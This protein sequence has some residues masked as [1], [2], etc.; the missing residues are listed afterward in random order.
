MTTAE[1]KIAERVSYARKVE[2]E[3]GLLLEGGPALDSPPIAQVRKDLKRAHDLSWALQV[4]PLFD[5]ACLLRMVIQHFTELR[6]SF[7]GTGP[8]YTGGLWV[9]AFASVPVSGYRTH[10]ERDATERDARLCEHH[11]GYYPEKALDQNRAALRK[12]SQAHDFRIRADAP[13]I[14]ASV[15]ERVEPVRPRFEAV[16]LV[17]EAEWAPS[18]VKDPLVIGR[19]TGVFFLIDQFDLT[20]ME[21][22]ISSEFCS[23]PESE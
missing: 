14:P 23:K 19:I 7:G 17:F 1:K 10:L 11:I 13:R 21:R 16:D 4:F 15:M 2:T 9:P 18:P 3:T 8:A 12:I 22:Y 6:P 5:P 20:K